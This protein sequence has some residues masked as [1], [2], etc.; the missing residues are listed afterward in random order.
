[1]KMAKILSGKV[2][3]QRIKDELKE[4]VKELNAT[5]TETPVPNSR[6]VIEPY[7]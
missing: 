4:E 3:S 6:G 2:V 5:I 7:N 1:M